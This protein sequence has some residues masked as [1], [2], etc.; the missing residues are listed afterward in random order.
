MASSLSA[1]D[2]SSYRQKLVPEKILRAHDFYLQKSKVLI[3]TGA[4]ILGA[5]IVAIIVGAVGTQKHYD[6]FTGEGSGYLVL[7]V[8][9]ISATATGIPLLIKGLVYHS[10]ANLILIN[11][12]VYRSSHL[13]VR[14]NIV[15][16]GI[17]IS[18]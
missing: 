7:W 3:P 2:D 16:A 11:E 1:Q 5:G 8:F 12:N 10:K 18:L 9:G 15:S 6:L 17:A 14:S 4:T 13:P